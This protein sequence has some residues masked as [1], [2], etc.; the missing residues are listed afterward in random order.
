M[1]IITKNKCRY[2]KNKIAGVVV[3]YFPTERVNSNIKT[4][5]NHVEKLWII[6]NTPN[7]LKFKYDKNKVEYIK[8]YKNL[9]IATA[10]NLAAQ[11]A[12]KEGYNWLLTMDQDSQFEKNSLGIMLE[13]LNCIDIE[14]IGIL[15]PFH[16]TK[17]R[18][19][20]YAN[21]LEKK[22]ITMTS[23]NLLNLNIYKE[24]GGFLDKLFIDEVDHE[25]C[26]RLIKNNYK[27]LQNNKSILKHEL[28]DIKVY[29]FYKIKI[30]ITNHSKIRQ[31]YMA[32]NR[33]YIIKKY[34]N[35]RIQYLGKVILKFIKV[36][37]FEKDKIKKIKYN[38]KGL[39]HG[40]LEKY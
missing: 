1:D 18:E 4:Y 19:H 7:E 35:K 31:Y 37:L 24:I 38:L 6:D 13:T 20:V 15:S 12:I 9:G 32:R 26:Y 29:K 16:K 39:V 10:L 14:K 5:I 27:I 2:E 34:S 17:G 22:E 40:V 30:I 21:E 23:G 8:L 3:L 11:K 33:V 36:L 25:Y 28:G